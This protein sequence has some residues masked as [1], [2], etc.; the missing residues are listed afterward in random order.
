MTRRKRP[1]PV[2]D[3]RNVDIVRDLARKATGEADDAPAGSRRRV[4]CAMSAL[5][6]WLEI[7]LGSD[8]A[9][10]DADDHARAI[11]A[12]HMVAQAVRQRAGRRRVTSPIYEQAAQMVDRLW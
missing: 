5:T 2:V 7:A 4:R 11:V 9:D 10:D 3:H 12:T 8:D 1:G 6:L